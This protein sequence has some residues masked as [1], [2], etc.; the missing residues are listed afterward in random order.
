MIKDPNLG[1]GGSAAWS[2]APGPADPA[3]RP[4]LLSVLSNQGLELLSGQLL[5]RRQDG[6]RL[7]NIDYCNCVYFLNR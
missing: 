5:L 2:A 7:T 6:P 4:T 1:P 3:L